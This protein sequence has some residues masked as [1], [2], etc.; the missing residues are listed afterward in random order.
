MIIAEFLGYLIEKIWLAIWRSDWFIWLRTEWI[1][2]SYN[3]QMAFL[4]EIVAI[5]GLLAWRC[6]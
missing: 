5:V 6:S 2:A 3:L 4:F 1:C